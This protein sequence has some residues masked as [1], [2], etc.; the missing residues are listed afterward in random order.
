MVMLR[1]ISKPEKNTFRYYLSLS[2]TDNFDIEYNTPIK[3]KQSYISVEIKEDA[4]NK[5]EHFW[6]PTG[7]IVWTYEAKTYIVRQY[8]Y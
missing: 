2:K 6:N 8:C 4:I 5:P 1:K 3:I 7:Q